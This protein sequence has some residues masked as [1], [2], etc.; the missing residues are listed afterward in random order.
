M[1]DLTKGSLARH[2][3]ATGGFMLFTMLFQTLYFLA[4]LYWM[5][6]GRAH[7]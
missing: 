4:D 3:F 7:V 6:I 2:L 5:E 1:N